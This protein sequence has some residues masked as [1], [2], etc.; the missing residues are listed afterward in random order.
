V[1]DLT[2]N[3]AGGIV[4]FVIKDGG[5][6]YNIGND[7]VIYPRSGSLC[8]IQVTSV[9]EIPDGDWMEVNPDLNVESYWERTSGV[10]SP[11]V[12]TDSVYVTNGAG[13]AQVQLLSTGNGSFAGK[14][15]TANTLAG[16]SDTT[17][18]TKKYVDDAISALETRLTT[19]ES[20]T[21]LLYDI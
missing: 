7:V 9:N 5:H 10:L 14:V 15:T 17:V 6:G 2:T 16:D 21:K 11:A 18:T 4:S 3:S 1:V 12:S 20:L 19:L 8:L 13:D